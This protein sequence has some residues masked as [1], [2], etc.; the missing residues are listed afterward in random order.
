MNNHLAETGAAEWYGTGR[1]CGCRP[2]GS[3]NLNTG[4]FIAGNYSNGAFWR[5][6]YQGLGG[7]Q[8]H[9][10]VSEIPWSYSVNSD[11]EIPISGSINAVTQEMFTI[12][13]WSIPLSLQITICII[14]IPFVGCV[15][16]GTLP[17]F[18]IATVDVPSITVDPSVLNPQTPLVFNFS[19]V[20]DMPGSG[21]EGPFSFGFTSPGMPGFF[22][23]STNP[24]SGFFNSG[25]GGASGFLNNVSGAVSGIANAF[26]QTSGIFNDGGVGVSGFQN[27]GT[28][29]SGWA[30]LGN[31]LSGVY[32]TS[33]LDMMHQAFI[34]GFGNYGS[35]LSGSLNSNVPTP[36]P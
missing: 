12:Q 2:D 31:F 10:T 28:L 18:H 9:G 32:N 16:S 20:I 3:G 8:Y 27:F 21:T 13:G 33:V 24:S 35:L 36:T 22:N 4:A 26:T 19:Q 5:G 1:H 7:Y 17:P 15:L 11:I 30:N 6:D 34:S 29:E 25:E 23:T 14:Y